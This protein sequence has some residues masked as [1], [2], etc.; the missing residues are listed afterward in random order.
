MAY[1]HCHCYWCC[2]S[3]CYCYYYHLTW[4]GC[5]KDWDLHGN[6]CYHVNDTPTL[7]WSDAQATCQNFGGDLAVIRSEDENNFTRY[8]VMKQQKVQDRG[9]WIG[10]YRKADYSFYWIDDTP[11][12]GHYSAWDSGEPNNWDSIENCNH[13]YA[14][15]LDKL[16]KWNDFLCNLVD[17]ADNHEAPVVL[18][19][20]K[21]CF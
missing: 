19:Q 18:C 1:C 4:L 3:Y 17:S 20:K 12:V 2:C 10:L 16:G 5:P 8:L 6:S 14:R 21:C 13:M 7:K 15:P 11:L 9:A